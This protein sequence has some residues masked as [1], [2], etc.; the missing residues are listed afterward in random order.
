MFVTLITPT[1]VRQE[2]FTLCETYMRRQTHKEFEWIV[3]DDGETPTVTAMGQKVI[4]A[5]KWSP[6]INTQRPNLNLGIENVHPKS[7]AIFIIED[8]DWYDRN[9]LEYSVDLLKHFPLVGG[10]CCRYYNIRIPGFKVHDNVSHCALSQTAVGKSLKDLLYQATNS[11]EF[12]IDINLWTK[13]KNQNISRVVYSDSNLVVGMKGLPGRGGLGIG[14]V[15]RD[16]QYDLGFEKLRKW[17]GFDAEPYVKI[18]EKY[19]S[20]THIRPK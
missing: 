14:H 5:P 8:D 9:Y 4:R 10:G 18:K 16:F 2:A 11:G 17:V 6:G 13:A 20:K 7:E 1:G 12:Y 3:V 15:E 19:F